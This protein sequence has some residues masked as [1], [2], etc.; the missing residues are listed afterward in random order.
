MQG[1]FQKENTDKA[2]KYGIY[3]HL[4]TYEKIIRNLVSFSLNISSVTALQPSPHGCA[5]GA[6]KAGLT[7]FSRS[8]FDE[9]RKY[10]VK[11]V[12]VHP[13]MTSTDLYRNADFKEDEDMAAH[14]EPQEV[15]QTVEYIINIRDGAVIQEITIKPQFHRIRRK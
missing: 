8:L 4:P 1:I 9:A 13:D 12:S 5:Y 10:G 11:V 3:R 2:L 14:L 6:S 7:A 15:A